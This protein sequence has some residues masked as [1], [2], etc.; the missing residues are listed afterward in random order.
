MPRGK[1]EV[2]RDARKSKSKTNTHKNVFKIPQDKSTLKTSQNFDYTTVVD[3]LRTVSLNKNIIQV[4]CL[5][6]LMENPSLEVPTNFQNKYDY[7]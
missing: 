1:Q 3:R 2:S 4:V 7:M 5:T 6:G